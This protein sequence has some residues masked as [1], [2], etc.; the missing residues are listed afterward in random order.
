MTEELTR[1]LHLIIK[2]YGDRTT[3]SVFILMQDFP[4]Y[5]ERKD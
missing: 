3:G 4:W 2:R 1:T 5:N